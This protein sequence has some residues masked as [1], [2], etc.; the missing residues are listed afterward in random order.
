M[1]NAKKLGIVFLSFYLIAEGVFLWLDISITGS[2]TILSIL[3]IA[4]GALLLLD[5]GKVKFGG[6][7]GM[8]LLAIWLVLHGLLALISLSF[9][10]S[11]VIM[12][13]LAIAAG[14]LLLIKR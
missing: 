7:L 14:V 11:D 4:A 5:R 2:E 10:G 12:A 6:N 1:M 9:S 13:L 8:L 3:A